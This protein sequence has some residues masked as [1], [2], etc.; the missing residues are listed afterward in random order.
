MSILRR[1]AKL[2]LR[3]PDI[4][5]VSF[6]SEVHEIHREAENTMETCCL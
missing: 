6:L 4:L 3:D 1:S 2:H 5:A